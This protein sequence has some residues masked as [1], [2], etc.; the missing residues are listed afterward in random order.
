MRCSRM[1]LSVATFLLLATA[2]APANAKTF[3]FSGSVTA[4]TTTVGDACAVDL[5]FTPAAAGSFTDSIDIASD[6]PNTPEASVSLVG[7]GTLPPAP[8]P[9]SRTQ[10]P[11]DFALEDP[12]GGG[13]FIATAAYGSH[14]D[15]HVEVLRRFRDDVL[16][17]NAPGRAFVE[18]YYASSPP[19]ADYIRRSEPLRAAVRAALTPV[20]Y[21][22]AYPGTALLVLSGL[23]ALSIGRRRAQAAGP[24]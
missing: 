12:G 14:L 7:A 1:T 22:L 4:C 18:F 9:G 19:V 15:P 5:T 10:Q 23:L 20:V 16:L 13:C 11:P 8:P 17:T 21:G 6:D 2:N 24:G 3:F